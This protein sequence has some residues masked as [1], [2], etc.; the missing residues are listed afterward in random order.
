VQERKIKRERERR[1]LGAHTHM[2]EYL[3]WPAH[4]FPKW[5]KTRERNEKG[6]E[7]GRPSLV[8]KPNGLTKCAWVRRVREK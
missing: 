6:G 2:H 3:A 5:N 1:N 7:H 8:S 4:I